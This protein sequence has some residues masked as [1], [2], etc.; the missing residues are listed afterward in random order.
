MDTDTDE[1]STQGGTHRARAQGT[2]LGRW[3][4]AGEDTR[5]LRQ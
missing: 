4:Q 2:N 3:L 1:G 5:E